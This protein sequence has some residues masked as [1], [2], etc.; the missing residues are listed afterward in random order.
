MYR[1]VCNQTSVS[2]TTTN[3]ATHPATTTAVATATPQPKN[4]QDKKKTGSKPGK[5]GKAGSRAL[6]NHAA[7]ICD[8]IANLDAAKGLDAKKVADLKTE[9]QKLEQELKVRGCPLFRL[10]FS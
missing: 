5:K 6:T 3:V 1:R 4:G 8:D 9:L 7:K 10:S 2:T